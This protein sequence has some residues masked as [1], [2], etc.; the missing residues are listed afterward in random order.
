MLAINFRRPS[1]RI[2]LLA[3]RLPQAADEYQEEPQEGETK[4]KPSP[5]NPVK[6]DSRD[7]AAE[8]QTE[9][10]IVLLRYDDLAAGRD[11]TAVRGHILSGFV[12]GR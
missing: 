11:L 4:E 3:F 2:F 9:N 10:G 8:V 1:L 7:M 6:S 5:Q 12:V